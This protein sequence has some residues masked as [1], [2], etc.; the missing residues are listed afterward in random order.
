MERWLFEGGIEMCINV[1]TTTSNTD[2]RK[3][4]HNVTL[5]MSINNYKL[6]VIVPAVN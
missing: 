6:V 2:D 1:L 5:V 4:T 3:A